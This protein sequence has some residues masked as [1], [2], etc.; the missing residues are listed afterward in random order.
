MD[1]TCI[2]V[3]PNRKKK[4]RLLSVLL[5][6][7]LARTIF[8]EKSSLIGKSLTV[9]A[10]S[11][12]SSVMNGRDGETIG[13]RDLPFE[14]Y[15][16]DEEESLNDD[17]IDCNGHNEESSIPPDIIVVA[18]VDG[19]LAGISKET[20]HILWKQSEKIADFSSSSSLMN[21]KSLLKDTSQFLKPLVATTT[22]T[23]YY[24]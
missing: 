24:Y 17:E 13:G 16:S 6:V 15:E 4:V 21:K 1:P 3:S 11:G 2:A 9:A 19:T 18:A 20:G 10:Y 14:T 5:W 8:R 12:S 7:G 22:T 23:K